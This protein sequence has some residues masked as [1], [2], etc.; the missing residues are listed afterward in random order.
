MKK[1]RFT[2]SQIVAVL[3]EA[4]AGVA[5][6]KG[7]SFSIS[8]KTYTPAESAGNPQEHRVLGQASKT[9]LKR[10]HKNLRRHAGLIDMTLNAGGEKITIRD[11][12]RNAPPTPVASIYPRI[13]VN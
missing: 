5:V 12:I 1:L 13:I 7:Q 9:P 6:S 8:G 10:R 2:E 4:E 3:K 11:L